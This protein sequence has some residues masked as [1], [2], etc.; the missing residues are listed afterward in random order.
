ML[1]SNT[2]AVNDLSGKIDDWR[3]SQYELGS[4]GGCGHNVHPP[5]R[6]IDRP[7]I[8]YDYGMGGVEGGWRVDRAPGLLRC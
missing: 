8:G 1:V 4:G 6:K 2:D 3:V 7:V 5:P